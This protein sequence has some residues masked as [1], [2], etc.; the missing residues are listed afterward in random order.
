MTITQRV[1][2]NLVFLGV[3]ILRFVERL[4]AIVRSVFVNSFRIALYLIVVTVAVKGLYLESSVGTGL[5]NL[6]EAVAPSAP[7]VLGISQAVTK[8]PALVGTFPVP[9]ISARSVLAKDV[10]SGKTLLEVNSKEKLAPASTTKLVTAL[11]S[12]DLYSLEDVVKVPEFCTTI[13][14]QKTGFRAEDSYTVRNLMESLLISSSADAAC[15]LSLGKVSYTEFVSLMNGEAA[16]HGLKETHFT[17]PVGLDS[18]GGDNYSTAEDLY[19]LALEARKNSLVVE[20]VQTK[21]KSIKSLE[22][23]EVQIQNTNELLWSLP[24]TVGIKTGR[25]QAAGEVLIYEYSRDGKDIIIVVM[26]SANRFLDT[27]NILNWILASYG[28]EV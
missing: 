20:S 13:E 2:I 6:P 26:G 7:N 15:A 16:K 23:N 8:A 12:L 18:D 25:T 28:W 24:G 21:E 22:G 27:Q 3:G 9:E 5:R 1:L 17:N 19:S 14:G 10:R 11:V 4:G